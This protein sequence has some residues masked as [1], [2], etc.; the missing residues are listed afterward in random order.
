MDPRLA[1][2]RMPTRGAALAYGV[3]LFASLA[4]AL[5]ARELLAEADGHGS[6]GG[7]PWALPFAALMALP[8]AAVFGVTLALAARGGWRLSPRRSAICAALL[9]ALA[10]AILLGTQPAMRLLGLGGDLFSGFA[11]AQL[12]LCVVAALCAAAL[13]GRGRAR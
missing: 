3:A 9:G 10:P 7:W 4:I 11:V 8:P 2:P 5:V 13:A 12:G 1:V 6:K